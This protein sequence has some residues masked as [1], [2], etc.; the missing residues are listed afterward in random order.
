MTPST[1][2]KSRQESLSISPLYSPYMSFPSTPVTIKKL[3][4]P[5]PLTILEKQQPGPAVRDINQKAKDG[6]GKI[7]ASAFP[8]SNPAV[9]HWHRSPPPTRVTRIDLKRRLGSDD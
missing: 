9:I 1:K 5:G 4:A 3:A 6:K 8:W 2:L 7:C